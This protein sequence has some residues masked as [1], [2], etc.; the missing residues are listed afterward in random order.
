MSA[1]KP[2]SVQTM[3]LV[4]SASR[5][6]MIELLPWAMLANGPAWTKAGP[7]SSVWS[8]FGLIASRSRTVIAPAT[9]R[10]S[11]VTGLPSVVVA[12]TIR[13]S[14]ARRS[15]RSVARARTAMT[16]EPTVMTNSVSRG[17]PSSRPPR[18][19]TTWR[20]ARSLMS[21]TRGQRIPCGSI[22]S[23]FLWWRLLSRNA[24]ARLC[25]APMAWTSPV[26]WRLKSSIGMTWL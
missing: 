10:S 12:R 5:S 15:N 20:S 21:T 19:M 24:P 2:A 6:A 26:R 17:T 8:R 13:P 22:P 11:A 25:A 4:T 23:G 1:P 16:S 3:S 18:P 14:R 7:P 9:P